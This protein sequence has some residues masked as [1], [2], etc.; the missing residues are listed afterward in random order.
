MKK[1]FFYFITLF[2][3]VNLVHAQQNMRQHLKLLKTSFITTAINLTPVEAEKFWPVY[4]KYS[5]EIQNLKITQETSIQHKIKIIG[6]VDNLTDQEA[7][8]LLD[9]F[10]KTE[11]Q[12]SDNEIKMVQ[13]LSKIISAKKIVALKKAERDF[14]RRILQE[15]AKR[16]RLQNN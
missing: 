4:N 3:S 1:V 11:K 13:E 15:Y 5:N 16:R 10:V 7:K 12:I 9:T 8:I 14:N 2:L 6:G